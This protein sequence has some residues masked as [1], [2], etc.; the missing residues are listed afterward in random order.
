MRK[1]LKKK[2]G[3]RSLLTAAMQRRICALLRQ[4]HTIAT[5][6]AAVGINESTFYDWGSQ[7]PEFS[8]RTTHARAN[9]KVTLVRRILAEKDWRAIAWYLERCWP[10]EFGKTAERQLPAD[11][12]APVC[13]VVVNLT[14]GP[15]TAIARQRFGTAPAL[16]ELQRRFEGQFEPHLAA[17]GENQ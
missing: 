7:F 5:T 9:G 17:N 6:C 8:K 4:G 3:R 1:R 12:Q 11:P 2:R 15:E 16:A 13:P 14:Y 10:Q